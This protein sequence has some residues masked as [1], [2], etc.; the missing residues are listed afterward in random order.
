MLELARAKMHDD[1]IAAI[2]TSEGQRSPSCP[3]KVLPITVQRI[4]LHAGLKG[5]TEQRTRWRHSTD[6]LSAQQ[7]AG[8]L[9]ISREL[10]LRSDQARAPFDRS[11]S[12]RRTSVLQHVARD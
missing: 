9:N 6:L 2:L 4:R 10:A 11:S 12:F 8:V 3:D 1:E 7:L 5:L